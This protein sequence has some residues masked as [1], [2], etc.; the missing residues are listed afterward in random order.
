VEETLTWLYIHR[1]PLTSSNPSI[2]HCILLKQTLLGNQKKVQQTAIGKVGI[3]TLLFLILS[4]MLVFDA[5][6]SNVYIY[7]AYPTNM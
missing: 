6:Y 1:P 2:K 5:E 7:A 4:L 3:Q